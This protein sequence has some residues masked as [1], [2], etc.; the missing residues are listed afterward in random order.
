MYNI[1]SLEKI[2]TWRG[3]AKGIFPTISIFDTIP[4]PTLT[5]ILGPKIHAHSG[6]RVLFDP[7]NLSVIFDNFESSVSFSPIVANH[8]T[9]NG[10]SLTHIIV[11]WGLESRQV[12]HDQG[13]SKDN[14]RNRTLISCNG[15]VETSFKMVDC[16]AG[17]ASPG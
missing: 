12:L 15:K 10:K 13:P 1:S 16:Y 9:S 3:L 7:R 4:L 14:Q 6:F 2:Y 5:L 11:R 8:D 17:I